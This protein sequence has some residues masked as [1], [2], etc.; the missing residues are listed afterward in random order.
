MKDKKYLTSADVINCLKQRFG[1]T[2]WAFLEQVA[3]GT[4]ARNYRW[5]D[6]IAMSVW[7][8]RGFDIHGIEV[9]ISR[10]DFLKELAQPQKS[11]AVQKYCNRW[12]IATSDDSI[13]QPG[14]LPPTWGWMVVNGKGMKVLTEAPPLTPQ[15]ISIE[16]LAAVMRN[17]ATT[18]ESE[19]ARRIDAAVKDSIKT[20]EIYAEEK[21]RK[22]HE[23]VAEFERRSGVKISEYDGPYMGTMVA[24]LRDLNWK[25]SQVEA[26]MKACKEIESMF[27][28]VIELKGLNATLKQEVEEMNEFQH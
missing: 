1:G 17:K 23:V 20:R 4:G 28:R 18:D 10:Y 21:S 9:K 8:S 6:A 3:P 16:F 14:E 2:A 7:P 5:A 25:L 27:A 26:G 11:E 22:L 13:V 15:P 12:W 19:V 24:I